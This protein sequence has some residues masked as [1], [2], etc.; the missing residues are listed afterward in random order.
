M[1]DASLAGSQV[2]LSK[3]VLIKEVR[4]FRQACG[5]PSYVLAVATEITGLENVNPSGM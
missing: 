4:R 2:I 1:W 3:T 5:S